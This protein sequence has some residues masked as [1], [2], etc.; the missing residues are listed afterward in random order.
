MEAHS[1]TII[2]FLFALLLKS[3]SKVLFFQKDLKKI[4]F[5]YKYTVQSHFWG[6]C[7]SQRY[8]RIFLQPLKQFTHSSI[9]GKKGFR[10]RMMT[11]TKLCVSDDVVLKFEDGRVRARNVLHD[12]LPVII[13][14][15][16]PT[17]VLINI[18][19]TAEQ[20]HTATKGCLLISF[21]LVKVQSLKLGFNLFESW[22][23]PLVS[24]C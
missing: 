14:G 11:N 4:P 20:T 24:P 7:L 10:S 18:P 6:T 8:K 9:A 23:Y 5:V 21:S 1:S 12:T 16:G 2:C 15:N 3:K 17:K 22:I 19:Y 13:H